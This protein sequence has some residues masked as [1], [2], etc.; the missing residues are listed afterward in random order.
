MNQHDEAI[1]AKL[2]GEHK[3]ALERHEKAIELLKTMSVLDPEWSRLLR[4]AGQDLDEAWLK[5][6]AHI[7]SMK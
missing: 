7:Q 1:L 5:L 6:D 3:E 2:V 4:Q